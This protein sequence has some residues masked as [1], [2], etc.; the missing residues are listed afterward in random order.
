MSLASRRLK[1]CYNIADFREFAKKR[2][3]KGVFEYL[4]RGRVELALQSV[5]AESAG[6]DGEKAVDGGKQKPDVRHGERFRLYGS[7]SP[8]RGTRRRHS[9]NRD[10]R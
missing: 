4:D 5:C 3:P 10:R 8:C 2:L 6:R 7:K 1:R 9:A